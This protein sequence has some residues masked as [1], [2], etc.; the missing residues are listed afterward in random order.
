MATKERKASGA[1]HRTISGL[2]LE[3]VRLVYWIQVQSI[4]L[5]SQ[6]CLF[7]QVSIA[8]FTL[9]IKIVV[10]F[11]LLCSLQSLSK[12]FLGLRRTKISAKPSPYSPLPFHALRLFQFVSAI[13]TS[14]IL[15]FFVYY[16]RD[17]KPPLPVPWTFIFVCLFIFRLVNP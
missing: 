8:C 4:F 9:G 15:C 1:D 12:M 16:L 10:V 13:I 17:E 6:V 2:P 14:S 11:R 5:F 7:N 3:M